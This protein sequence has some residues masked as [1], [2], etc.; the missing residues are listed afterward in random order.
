VRSNTHGPDDTTPSYAL[1]DIADSWDQSTDTLD[2]GKN[3]L[4]HSIDRT[5]RSV[6]LLQVID[7]YLQ[8]HLTPVPLKPR[9]KEPPR[10][11]GNG[12]NLTRQELG[13]WFANHTVNT[14]LSCGENLAV[15]DCDSQEA[16]RNFTAT[17]HLPP[18]SRSL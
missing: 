1:A 14:G 15:I 7:L 9:C 18:G 6:N 12:W 17:H 2:I 8:L 13:Q 10:P 11:W 5:G 4:K 3:H 16:F